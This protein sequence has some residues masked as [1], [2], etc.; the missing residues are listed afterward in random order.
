MIPATTLK[1]LFINTTQWFKVY[2]TVGRTIEFLQWQQRS[3]QSRAG[4][5]HSWH[6]TSAALGL[7]QA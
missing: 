4:I 3:H 7:Q 5:R 2:V 1:F 6:Q